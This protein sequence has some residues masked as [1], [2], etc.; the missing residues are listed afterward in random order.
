MTDVERKYFRAIGK[1]QLKTNLSV[2]THVPNQGCPSCALE[3]LDILESQG[4]DPLRVCV[5]HVADFHPHQD[6]GWQTQKTL[7]KRGAWLG[8][9]SVG[10]PL[11]LA[12]IVET[13]DAQKV[14]MVLSLLDAGY[15][16]RLMFSSDF[17]KAKNLKANFGAGL[18]AVMTV[19]IPK[20]RHAGV[21]DAAIRR[22]LVDNPRRFFAFVPRS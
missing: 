15:E 17:F 8:F 5:G 10:A 19:F 4:V 16:D 20:L 14:K 13:T 12:N 21:S 7:A 1:A 3:Q 18:S 9:D 6:P 11:E 2:F 22:M